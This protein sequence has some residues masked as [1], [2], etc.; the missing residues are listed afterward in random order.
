LHG[1]G[2]P[3]GGPFFVYANGKVETS[4]NDYARLDHI[5]KQRQDALK[6]PQELAEMSSDILADKSD[7]HPT[8]TMIESLQHKHPEWTLARS[9]TYL[10]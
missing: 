9:V 1:K 5:A 4:G 8:A 7:Q 10:C 3:N 2:P 6:R